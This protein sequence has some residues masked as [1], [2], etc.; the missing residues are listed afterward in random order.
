MAFVF[1]R[2]CHKSL[3]IIKLIKNTSKQQEILV[4]TKNPSTNIKE[5]YQRRT[6]SVFLAKRSAI[7]T[8][9]NI[10]GKRLIIKPEHLVLS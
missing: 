10:E 1:E 2:L 3:K 6:G 5:A 4:A 8:N 7:T 9:G